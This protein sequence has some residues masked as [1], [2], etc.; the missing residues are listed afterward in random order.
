MINAILFDLNG[1]LIDSEGLNVEV[2]EKVYSNYSLSFS[3]ELYMKCID[4]RTTTE[5]ARELVEKEKILEFVQL[6]DRIWYDLFQERG[7]IVFEDTVPFL[8]KLKKRGIKTAV[9]TSSR[10]AGYILEYLNI[11]QYFDAIIGGGDIV[12]GK[13][14]PEIVLKA[15]EL[16][17]VEKTEVALVEDSIAGLEAGKRAGV[18][19]IAIKRNEKNDLDKYD[20]LIHSLNEIVL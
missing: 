9:I 18:Y 4:G 20:Q 7:V 5:I 12:C 11:A 2:W 15:M 16:L 6:K 14:N 17:G 10:K 13:P 1:V 8:Q 3:E 19:C